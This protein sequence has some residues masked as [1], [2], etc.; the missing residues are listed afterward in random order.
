MRNN[1]GLFLFGLFSCA[2]FAADPVGV[3]RAWARITAP[4]QAMGVAY[5]TLQSPVDTTLLEVTSPA[6]DQIEIHKMSIN[7]GVMQM[8]ML[9]TLPLPAGKA[10]KFEPG[11]L[12]LMLFGLHDGMKHGG[13]FLLTLKLADKD[14]KRYSQE[15]EIATRSAAE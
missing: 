13:R 3:T 4:E 10:V 5:M 9:K 6:A 11:G 7:K 12:H 8:R 2:S 14:G 1:I 15:V